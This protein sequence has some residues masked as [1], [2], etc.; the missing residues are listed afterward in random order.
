MNWKTLQYSVFSMNIQ[1]TKYN[2]TANWPR[3]ETF[4]N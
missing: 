2:E 3:V 4:D 1:V